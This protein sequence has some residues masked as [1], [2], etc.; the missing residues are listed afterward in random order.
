MVREP[1]L[2]II[3]IV[4]S[5]SQLMVSQ[6]IVRQ[7]LDDDVLEFMKLASRIAVVL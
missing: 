4:E 1:F 7:I 5:R 3:N 2:I 6:A